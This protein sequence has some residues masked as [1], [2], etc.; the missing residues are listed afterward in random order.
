[1]SE[2][3]NGES[4]TGVGHI[5]DISGGA[6]AMTRSPT[7]GSVNGMTFSLQI[8]LVRESVT[9]EGGELSMSTLTDIAC[10]FVD[11][12]VNRKF[13]PCRGRGCGRGRGLIWG[14]VKCGQS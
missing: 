3:S 14:C 8:G 12:K 11:K 10:A 6:L 9:F 4:K 13:T 2:R 7:Q 5:A 1:M